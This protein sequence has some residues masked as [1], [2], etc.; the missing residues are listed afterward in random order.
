MKVK[1]VETTPNA[2]QLIVEIAR[3]SSSRKDKTEEPHRLINYLIRNKHW[4]PFEHGHLT[5]E[6]ETSRG[7]AAQLLRHR[8]FTFQEFSQRYQDVNKI[9]DD[10]IFEP[11]ELRQQAVT[12]RQSSTD[13]FNPQ[14]QVPTPLSMHP[15]VYKDAN[16]VVDDYLKL[17][18]D[19]YNTLIEAGVAKEC[20]RFILPLTTKTKIYMTGTVRS[21][22][23]FIQLRDDGHAQKEAQLIAKEIKKIFAD[24]FPEVYKALYTKQEKKMEEGKIKVSVKKNGIEMSFEINLSDVDKIPSITAKAQE[25][26]ATTNAEKVLRKVKKNVKK[27]SKKEYVRLDDKQKQALKKDSRKLGVDELVTKYGVS[28]RTVYRVLS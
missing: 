4:S 3:V 16:R 11:I 5:V 23:H 8:S 10:G 20:A 19:L 26:F 21:W 2:E 9:S 24:Q 27:P 22:I 28:K 1:F 13:V 6:I 12:N 15:E 14:I 17:S 25:K 7:I 18:N